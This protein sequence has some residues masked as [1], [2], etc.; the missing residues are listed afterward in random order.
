MIE[1]K[2]THNFITQGTNSNED[3]YMVGVDDMMAIRNTWDQ[4]VLLQALEIFQGMA[5]VQQE[6]Y[7]R[8]ARESFNKKSYII[9]PD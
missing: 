2:S 7:L 8:G 5:P 1:Y 9:S 4:S 6:A 3:G